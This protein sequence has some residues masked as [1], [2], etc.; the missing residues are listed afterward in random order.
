VH[1]EEPQAPEQDLPSDQLS[2]DRKDWEAD[3]RI[4]PKRKQRL[5]VDN[6]KLTLN[7]KEIGTADIW[8]RDGI[9]QGYAYLDIGVEIVD[10]R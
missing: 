2:D 4:A 9:S 1:P 10:T 8:K 5:Y 7:R 3:W 6:G